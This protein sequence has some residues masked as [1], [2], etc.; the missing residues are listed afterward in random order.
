MSGVYITCSH[1]RPRLCDIVGITCNR[2]PVTNE[3]T[4]KQRFIIKTR[5]FC[6]L[7]KNG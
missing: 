4:K 3:Q 6:N 1:K 5:T 2:S 7:G